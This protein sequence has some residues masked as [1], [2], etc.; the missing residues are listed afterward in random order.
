MFNS[1]AGEFVEFD[2]ICVVAGR[3]ASHKATFM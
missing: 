3:P 1:D 2:L